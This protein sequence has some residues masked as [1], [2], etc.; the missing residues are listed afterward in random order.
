VAI[1]G[2]GPYGLS[3]AAHLQFKGIKFR[4]F[5]SP[6][7]RWLEQM[8]K[9]MFL[10]SE[11][12]A[13]N[14]SDPSGSRSLAQYCAEQ[15]LPYGGIGSPVPR[16]TLVRYALAFQRE[17]VPNVEEVT[18]TAV[19]KSSKG[20]ELRLSSGEKLNA[21]KVIVATGLDYMAY[22][23]PELAKLPR[24]LLSHSSDHHD[25]SHFKGREV[26]VIGGGQSAIETAALLAEAGA[27][28]R[29]LVMEA[30]LAWEPVPNASPQTLYERVRYPRTCLGQGLSSW[31]YCNVPQLFYRLPQRTRIARASRAAPPAGAWW[32]KDR[33]IGRFP[34][35][36]GHHVCG[37]EAQ[38][39]RALLNVQYDGQHRHF[40]ADHVIA[41]TGYRFDAKRLPLLSQGLKS[42]LQYEARFPRLSPNF[43]SSVPGLYFTSV[44]SLYA[45]GAAM[46]FLAGTDFTARRIANH[47]A[48]CQTATG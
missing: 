11:G 48:A 1:V 37:A 38:G 5:G 22:V 36:P 30:S 14:L 9:G 34:V 45:F 6:M 18:V 46:R 42:Q 32:L 33:V 26:T 12:C 2:A 21:G 10:K 7:R 41:A 27:P 15:G 40:T 13:S 17:L 31:I 28:V 47:I 3:I 20:F 39:S 24:D 29:L 4:I 35:L 8:P 16:E 19:E 23:P 25:F 43:E 44:A